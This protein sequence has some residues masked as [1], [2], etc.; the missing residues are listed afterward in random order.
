M[1]KYEIKDGVQLYRNPVQTMDKIKTLIPGLK[2]EDALD[3]FWEGTITDTKSGTIPVYVPNLMDSTSKLLDKVT[4]Q[5]II[6]EAIPDLPANTKKVIVYYVDITSEEEIK[7]FIEEDDSTV[8][9]IELRDLKTILDDVV[10]GDYVEFTVAETEGELIDRYV[11]SIDRFM[12]D[13]VIAKILEFNNKCLLNDKKKTFKPIQISEEGLEMIEYLS[14]DCESSEGEW[15][16]SSEIKI[17]KNSFVI[18][19]GEKTKT[20]WDG[21]IKSEKKPLRLKIRNIC[22]DETVWKI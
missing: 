4:M 15:H 12:S 14:L 13:R 21:A 11:V 6:H 17:D 3:S 10:I 2:N 16:S 8:V 7:K 22:G 19:N 20:F 1:A 5:R 9:E 18:L